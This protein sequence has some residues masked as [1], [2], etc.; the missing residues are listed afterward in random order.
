MK[1]VL[2]AA[3]V[4]GTLALAAC[5]GSNSAAEN[6]AENIEATADNVE[7]AAENVADNVTANAENTAD[8]LRNEADQVR[9]NASNAADGN[10]H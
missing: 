10:D 3:A 7:D 1:I 2:T 9:D 8:A 4:A 6:K 5:G